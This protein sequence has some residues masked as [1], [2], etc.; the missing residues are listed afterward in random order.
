MVQILLAIGTRNL[1]HFDHITVLRS[2]S[3]RLS[4]RSLH[5]WLM[6]RWDSSQSD[7]TS[8]QSSNSVLRTLVRSALVVEHIIG[9]SWVGFLVE[10]VICLASDLSSTIGMAIEVM[11]RLNV[12]LRQEWKYRL[13]LVWSRCA[14]GLPLSSLCRVQWR[15][16][17]STLFRLFR[18]ATVTLVSRHK[19]LLLFELL[20]DQC[21]RAWGQIPIGSLLSIVSETKRNLQVTL[22]CVGGRLLDLWLF[23]RQLLTNIMLVVI[24]KD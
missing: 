4:L 23:K 3:K 9:L 6:L 20:L 17:G 1:I 11:L 7:L 15:I 19:L 16:V 22:T 5:H 10:K 24:I 18:N 14:G 2:C 13:T 12:M 21:N 8:G